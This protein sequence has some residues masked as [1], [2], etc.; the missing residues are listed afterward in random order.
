MVENFDGMAVKDA[1]DRKFVESLPDSA[2]SSPHSK[3]PSCDVKEALR[4]INP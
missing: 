1:P 4:R 3:D 2:Y